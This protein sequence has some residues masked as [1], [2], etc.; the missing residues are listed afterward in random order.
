MPLKRPQA[1]YEDE[2]VAVMEIERKAPT[3]MR[4]PIGTPTEGRRSIDQTSIS[5]DGDDDVFEV[6][7]IYRW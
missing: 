2:D 4:S 5:S 3:T 7:K 6:V 1:D